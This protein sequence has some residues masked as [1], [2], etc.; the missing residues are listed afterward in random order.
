MHLQ[1]VQTLIR[2]FLQE[3][4]DV[5]LYCLKLFNTMNFWYTFNIFENSQINLNYY[6][7][8]VKCHN[9]SENKFTMFHKLTDT[10]QIFENDLANS[11][12]FNSLWAT[13]T[14]FSVSQ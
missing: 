14:F 10:E 4:S 8:W 6:S 5:G 12:T 11:V 9:T 7:C 1:T 2:L 13:L 3:Q